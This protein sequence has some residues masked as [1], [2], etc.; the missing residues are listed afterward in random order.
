MRTSILASH[1]LQTIVLM[2]TRGDPF[3]SL[4]GAD[5]DKNRWVSCLTQRNGEKKFYSCKN[6]KSA[7]TKHLL[8]HI[9]TLILQAIATRHLYLAVF[10][11]PLNSAALLTLA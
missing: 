4:L 11:T 3:N 6:P 7:L 2:Q 8:L 1:L 9:H 10:L 5:E